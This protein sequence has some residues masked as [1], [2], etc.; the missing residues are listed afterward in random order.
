MSLVSC[1]EP[2]IAAQNRL[3]KEALL[4]YV[5]FMIRRKIADYLSTKKFVIKIMNNPFD[6]FDKTLLL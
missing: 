1:Q 4:L 5:F 3:P 6:F 2:A